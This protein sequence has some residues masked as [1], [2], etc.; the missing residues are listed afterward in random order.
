MPLPLQIK[1]GGYTSYFEVAFNKWHSTSGIQPYRGSCIYLLTP[2]ILEL[3]LVG[4]NRGLTGCLSKLMSMIR[5]LNQKFSLMSLILCR[6]DMQLQGSAR[7]C[8]NCSTIDQQDRSLSNNVM[9][10]AS[11]RTPRKFQ[12]Y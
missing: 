10:C 6:V 7:A 2:S 5:A 4:C 3:Q 12:N 8:G 9:C 1:G 11:H